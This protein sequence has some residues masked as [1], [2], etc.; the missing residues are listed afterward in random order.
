[1]SA[2]SG[3]LEFVFPPD[4]EHLRTLRHHLRR[5]LVELAVFG[6]LADSVVL[7]VDEIVTNA[8][9]HARPYRLG[10]G[11]LVL[12][13]ERRA[14]RVWLD[15]E[16][17]DVPATV[18]QELARVLAERAQPVDP[19][20]ERGRGLLLVAENVEALRIEEGP[21]GGMRLHGRFLDMA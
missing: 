4:A 12:R 7:V 15:F 1:M 10:A 6:E 9:E 18:V 14:D 16:D 19:A 8:I 13:L 2:K 21:R 5:K 11:Q 17:P 3:Q 20:A